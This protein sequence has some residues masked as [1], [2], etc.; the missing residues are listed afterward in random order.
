M[1]A[2]VVFDQVDQRVVLVPQGPQ[3]G[4]DGGVIQTSSYGQGS[5]AVLDSADFE[6]DLSAVNAAR[7][8]EKLAR[9]VDHGN[10][11]R[12]QKTRRVGRGVKPAVS[13]RDQVQAVRE[14]VR[15]NGYTASAR[16]RIPRSVQDAFDTAH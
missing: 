13:G 11:V 3:V 15:Q 9:Y 5:G 1:Q 4:G 12:P 8:R 16:V 14:W 7:L 2:A 6:M 10:R